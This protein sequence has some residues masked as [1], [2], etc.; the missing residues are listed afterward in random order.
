[1][2][3]V[4]NDYPKQLES[5]VR[6][7]YSE[8]LGDTDLKTMTIETVRARFKDHGSSDSTIIK[9]IAFFFSVCVAAQ[10]EMSPHVLRRGSNNATRKP[11]KKNVATR[12]KPSEKSNPRKVNQVPDEHE[13]MP[14]LTA[15]YLQFQIAIPNF[16]DGTLKLPKKMGKEEWQ[17]AKKMISV[18]LEIYTAKRRVTMRR[19]TPL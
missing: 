2:V 4:E 13:E 12:K 19:V 7:A 5:L 18:I 11:R 3:S 16:P 6:D 8:I 15:G 17:I 9:S 10:M 1:M 14:D